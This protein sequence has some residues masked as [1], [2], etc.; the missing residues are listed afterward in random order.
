MNYINDNHDENDNDERAKPH[1]ETRMKIYHRQNRQ[2]DLWCLSLIM[3][4]RATT[5]L[6]HNRITLPWRGLITRTGLL[7]NWAKSISLDILLI[8]TVKPIRLAFWLLVHSIVSP[9]LH[10]D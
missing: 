7:T 10:I 9:S 2:I 3:L 1:R 8:F 5:I 6:S 4:L